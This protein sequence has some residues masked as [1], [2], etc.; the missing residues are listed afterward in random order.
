MISDVLFDAIEDLKQYT[1]DPYW[2]SVYG[3]G[4]MAEAAAVVAA[5]DSLRAKLDKPPATTLEPPL[6]PCGG[7][8]RT[9][10]ITDLLI[11]S[12]MDAARKEEK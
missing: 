5:M 7:S 8:K 10:Q 12:A 4:H 3:V 2:Q 9:L 11:L 6:P 1:E